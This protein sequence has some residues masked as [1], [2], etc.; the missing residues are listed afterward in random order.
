MS[1]LSISVFS[2]HD[3]IAQRGAEMRMGLL[4]TR[5]INL[6]AGRPVVAT[7]PR[8][9]GASLPLVARWASEG[10]TT[11]PPPPPSGKRTD[12]VRTRGNS[13]S[14]SP[15]GQVRA[16]ARSVRRAGPACWRGRAAE[17]V[18]SRAGEGRMGRR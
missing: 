8:F 4:K 3:S 16:R 17:V 18:R 6:G 13:R 12:V 14:V 11:S 10:L 2:Y 1:K 5:A 15:K 9:P 7:N